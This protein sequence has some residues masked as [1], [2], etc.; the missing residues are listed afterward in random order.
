MKENIFYWG[1]FIDESIGTKKAIF[2]S[3]LSINKF[4]KK[5]ESSIINSIGEWDK[6]KKKKMI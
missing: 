2:N 3:A 6:E 4:S 1:P 5:Y